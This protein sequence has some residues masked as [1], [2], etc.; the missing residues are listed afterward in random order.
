MVFNRRVTDAEL[1]DELGGPSRL[2]ERLGYEKLGGVQRVQNWKA[3]GIPARVKL[4]RPDLF[5]VPQ[6]AAAAPPVPIAPEPAH[7]TT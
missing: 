4:Q 5:L 1:I 7:A 3:R 6:P 2:A